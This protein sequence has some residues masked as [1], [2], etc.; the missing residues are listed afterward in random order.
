MSRPILQGGNLNTQ[1]LFAPDS[2]EELEDLMPSDYK[3]IL[4][5]LFD[6]DVGFIPDFVDDETKGDKETKGRVRPD[7]PTH[8]S[9]WHEG[10]AHIIEEFFGS[11]SRQMEFMNLKREL[12]GYPK[13]LQIIVAMALLP[14]SEGQS[15]TVVTNDD[16]LIDIFQSRGID[17]MKPVDFANTMEDSGL[18]NRNG[19]DLVFKSGVVLTDNDINLLN[20]PS[21]DAYVRA[22][23]DD[24]RRSH[25]MRG[26]VSTVIGAHKAAK[27]TE[28][29]LTKISDD[30]ILIDS[31]GA[32]ERGGSPEVRPLGLPS[33]P[34]QEQTTTSTTSG[35]DDDMGTSGGAEGH[36]QNLDVQH[37]QPHDIDE[38]I[39]VDDEEE[40]LMEE[41]EK[42]TRDIGGMGF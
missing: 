23:Q 33:Q 26:L 39:D 5:D 18:L 25:F 41:A 16:R 42:Q 4:V 10:E 28:Q 14:G 8:G 27:L 37:E 7:G 22:I 30:V 21:L 12:R 34:S 31:V 15:N 3:D 2:A 17:F 11:R 36:A 9:Q 32:N 29:D 13:D 24:E 1:F 40:N 19:L 35:D 6:D 38:E 20:D